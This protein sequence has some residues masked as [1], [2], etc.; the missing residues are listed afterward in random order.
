VLTCLSTAEEEQQALSEFSRVLAPEGILVV[1]FFNSRSHFTLIRKHLLKE[2]I[3]PPEYVSPS[4]FRADLAEAGFEVLEFRGFDFKPCQGYL[5][6]SGLRPFIDP[7]FIQ[8]RI[9]RLLEA[10]IL[11]RMPALSLLGYRIYVKCKKIQD[12]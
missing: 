8:E 5:F 4:N 1:D 11:H 10:R 2:S 12:L 6:L 7:C 9:S 3:A